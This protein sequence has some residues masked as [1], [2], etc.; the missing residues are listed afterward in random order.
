VRFGQFVR[1]SRGLF[2]AS[3]KNNTNELT[4]TSHRTVL[5]VDDAPLIIHELGQI[6]SEYR[7]LPATDGETALRLAASARPDLI[8][9]DIVMP[10]MDGHRVCRRLKA[11][12]KTREIPVI[13]LTAKD[14]SEDE[15]KGLEMG[16]VDYIFKPFNASVVR[17]RTEMH[18]KIDALRKR[19]EAEMARFRTLAHATFEGIL[20]HTADSVLDANEVALQLCGRSRDSL[21]GHR[22]DTLFPSAGLEEIRRGTLHAFES[23]LATSHRGVIPVELQTANIELDGELVSVTA[24]RDLSQKREME[25]KVHRLHAE[26]EALRSDIQH[27]YKFGDIVGRSASMQAV[28]ELIT[29][30]ATSEYSVVVE[31]ES[32]TGKEL[33]AQT[34][35]KLSARKSRPFVTVNCGAVADSIF[36]REFFGHRR[37]AF[38]GADRD[39][40]GYLA[41]ANG[42]SLLLDE[43][44]EMSMPLQVK[45]LRVLESGEYTPLG[46]TT[47]SNTDARIIA[48]TN[49][50]LS[51]EVQRGAFREDL[52][53]RLFVI[54][55]QVPPLRERREDIPLLV[56][57]FLETFDKKKA[58]RLPV[59]HLDRLLSYDWPGNA[60]ELQNAIQRFLA[61]GSFGLP[62]LL[63]DLSDSAST[64]PEA[65]EALESRMIH[66]AIHRA[67]G[68]RGKAAE[69]LNIPRRTLQRKMLKYGM[70]E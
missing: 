18:M 3:S 28:Y 31:G 41:A 24:I 36:E 45:L 54:G 20:I 1:A 12:P 9:L 56:E 27:R 63:E 13:F 37:G 65:I 10:G 14:R 25:E 67:D 58:R 5:V 50:D 70:R 59:K 49:R 4:L 69:L 21:L 48:A 17:A 39:Q 19:L 35:H 60:R 42:G 32:G 52:Y 16:A 34:I 6:L 38:T 22:W 47:P 40:P 33:V 15:A 43:I 61:T 68:H 2:L 64:L 30:A 8:L 7:V 57:H 29:Q 62:A 46:A 23:E 11:D 44:G 66:E 26:N 53:Y 55:I 51:E